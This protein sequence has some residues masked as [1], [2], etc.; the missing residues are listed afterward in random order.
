MSKFS[1]LFLQNATKIDTRSVP[2]QQDQDEADFSR[3]RPGPKSKE[4]PGPK[5]HKFG[6][7]HA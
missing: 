4:T 2:I 3:M 1:S 5:P 6:S 7:V